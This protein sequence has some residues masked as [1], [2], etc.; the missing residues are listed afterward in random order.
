MPCINYFYYFFIYITKLK[1]WNPSVWSGLGKVITEL[2]H[3]YESA[4]SINSVSLNRTPASHGKG[5]IVV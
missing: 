3:E 1:N 4:Q 2:K 5:K